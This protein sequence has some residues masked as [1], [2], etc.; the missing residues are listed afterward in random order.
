MAGRPEIER[1]EIVSLD[2]IIEIAD[3][4]SPIVRAELKELFESLNETDRKVFILR[5]KGYTI[6][7]IAE[8]LNVSKTRVRERLSR[9][10]RR[11]AEYVEL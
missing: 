3:G 8:S 4:E 5:A 10:K 6:K 1:L 7:E 9:I 11:I 2:G